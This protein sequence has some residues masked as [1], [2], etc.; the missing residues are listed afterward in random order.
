MSFSVTLRLAALIL[1]AAVA[2]CGVTYLWGRLDG[3]SACDDRHDKAIIQTQQKNGKS[4]AKIKRN[5]P[6]DVD[7]AAGIKFL[8]DHAGR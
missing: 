5:A 7:R 3:S 2:L 6:G 1:A 4:D 8:L